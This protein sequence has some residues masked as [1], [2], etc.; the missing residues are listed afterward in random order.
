M[1][2][3]PPVSFLVSDLASNS[4]GAVVRMAR[5]LAPEFPSEIVGPCLRGAPNEMYRREF[6]FRVVDVPRVYRFP[7]F[8]PAV[9]KL[10]DAASGDV[11]VVMKAFAPALPAALLAKKRRGAR[12]AVYLDEW[13]G[14]TPASWSP[15]ERLRHALRDC[16]HPCDD[17]WTPFWER[18][19]PRADLLLGTTTFLARKFGAVR[20][21]LGADADFFRPQPPE[22]A[23][24]LRRELGL[25]GRRLLVFG[26]VARAHKGLEPFAEGAAAAGWTLL[27]AGPANDCA[28]SL[29]ARYGEAVRCTGAIP[30]ADM[31]RHLALADALA[32]P[33]GTGLLASSQMPCKLY[34]A[35]A[36]AK[37]VLASAVSDVPDV[38]DG[39]GW[40]VPPGDPAAVA[41]ALRAVAADPAEAARRAAAARARCVAEYAAPVVGARLRD[42]V[43]SLAASP[44]L[45]RRNACGGSSTS[46]T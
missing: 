7:D 10:A 38:L 43:R 40:T 17:L 23:A 44:A 46:G 33:L 13:D 19:L 37:P 18:R 12:V 45:S 32:V 20:Y 39:C 4:V 35:M 24:A 36:M 6:P 1:P 16:L 29:Q 14:A 8:F 41:D 2:D 42:L 27:L 34:E 30:H 9:R 11:L 15:R 22:S 31:P 21:D 3:R 5:H 26:G 25:E 28:A